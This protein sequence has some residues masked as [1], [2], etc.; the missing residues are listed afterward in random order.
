MSAD[1]PANA[2]TR[3][4][5]RAGDYAKARPSYPA[6]IV[7]AVLEGLG[8]PSA[9]VI[10]DIGAGTGVFSRLL[11]DRGPRVLAVEP[12]ATMREAAAPHNRVEFR[13]GTGE[14]TGLPDRA[15]NL[16]TVAQAFHWMRPE[17][18]LREFRRVLVPGGRLAHVWNI[19][20]RA[21]PF[22]DGYCAAM[23]RHA[24]DPPRSPWSLHD[25]SAVL[26]E[27]PLFTPRRIV[28]VPSAQP[29]TLDGLLGRARSASYCPKASP[30]WDALR[31][32]LVTLHGR[33][34]TEGVASLRYSSEAHISHAR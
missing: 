18:A 19:Q 21:D 12:N 22:T 7:D 29:L 20:D 26:D 2:T 30:G 33:H 17:E 4:A 31:H 25:V 8:E 34:A 3:F 1:P 28:R 24:V 9:L 14:A 16:V 10:A 32:E 27:H 15:A 5:D 6:E 23:E 11:A 13:E